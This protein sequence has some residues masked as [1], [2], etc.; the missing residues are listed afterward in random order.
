MAAMLFRRR[1]EHEG[2]LVDIAVDGEDGL[3]QCGERRYDLIA[4]DYQYA[5]S[6]TGSAFC[7]S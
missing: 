5:R 3:R 2:Y 6:W 1:L 7:A 4:L